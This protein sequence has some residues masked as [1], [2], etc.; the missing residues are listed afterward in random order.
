MV[1]SMLFSMGLP[2]ISYYAF[3]PRGLVLGFLV[4]WRSRYRFLWFGC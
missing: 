1:L 4:G 2:M 3:H